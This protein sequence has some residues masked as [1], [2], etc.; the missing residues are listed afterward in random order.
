M[1][2]PP[3][4]GFRPHFVVGGT[5]KGGTTAL[6]RFLGAHPEICFAKHKE[7]HFF[8]RPDFPEGASFDALN[9]AY[10][11]KFPPEWAGK[12]VGEGTPIYMYLPGVAERIRAYYPDMR[13]VLL[14]RHPVDRAVSHYSMEWA[15]GGEWLPLPLALRAERF[16]CWYDQGWLAWKTSLRHHSY[17]DRGRYSGQIERLWRLFGRERVLVLTHEELRDQHAETLRRVYAFLGVQRRDLIP[18][19]EAVFVTGRKTSVEPSTR[20][21]MLRRMRDEVNR[22]EAMLGRSL[23]GWRC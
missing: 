3:S 20:A 6:A 11:Q 1:S 8:D 2:A 13:W 22:L 21:W 15:R 9:V 5:Q 19:Q 10:A 18:A 7:A 12:I 4:S 23:A 14:L 16:R 17:L